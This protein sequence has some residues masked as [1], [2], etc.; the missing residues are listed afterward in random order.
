MMTIALLLVAGAT[1]TAPIARGT[2]PA[3]HPPDA[4]VRALSPALAA[5]REAERRLG[6][7]EVR[8]A[9]AHRDLAV[10][11]TRRARETGDAAFYDEALR[12]LENAERLE[13]DGAESRL[14]LA[15]VRMGRH[16]FAEALRLARLCARRDP[17]DPRALGVAG[18]ALMELG[19]YDEAEAAYQAMLDLRPDPA[20]WSR[21]AHLL[22]VRGELREAARLMGM[23]LDATSPREAEDR[24]WLLV[25][26][27][28]LEEAMGEGAAA[29][30]SYH[31]ALEVF[32]DYHL[33]LAALARLR[34]AAG[35]PL[36]AEALA[37]RA[38]AAA[39]HAERR[40]VL[41]DA[42]HAQ[43]RHE[44]AGA[45]ERAFES[46]AT[47]HAG[48]AD[49]ENHDLV[50]YYLDRRP[51]PRRALEIA[52]REA[53]ARRDVQTLDRLAW[54]LHHAGRRPAAARL[55]RAIAATGSRDPLIAA[56]AAA[57]LGA[58]GGDRQ[59]PAERHVEREA[60]AGGT[61]R[62]EPR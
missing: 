21:A 37:R 30:R 3:R 4:G 5:I 59:H 49:N 52:R 39:P 10:A 42:L 27:G 1:A 61:G 62:P 36:D 55:M 26:L 9:A 14:I 22:E 28:H 60:G 38:L 12:A 23:A 58:R 56:H 6:S 40:L 51:D 50:L 44:E 35:S 13:P 47:R 48:E 25:Q 11:L 8:T 7:G 24:A 57:I 18:D 16:E 53:R 41:A 17:P 46:L 19:R 33:A 43:G 2:P 45:E 34:L 20:S 54:A 32:P 31:R 15:W 29:G